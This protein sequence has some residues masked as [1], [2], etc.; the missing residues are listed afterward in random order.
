[1]LRRKLLVIL[2]PLVILLLGT[3]AGTVWL[4][5]EQESLTSRFRWLV[6]GIG[7]AF[8][9][10]INVAVMVLLRMSGMILRPIDRLVE[11]SRQLAQERFDHR[12]ELP[13]PDDEFHEL[14]RAYNVLA[15]Q[16]QANE[17]RKMEMLGQIALTLNHELNNA[18]AVIELRLRPLSRQCSGNPKMHDCFQQIHENLARMARTVDALKRVRRIVLTD[19]VSG[20]KMLDLER[21]VEAEPAAAA[22]PLTTPKTKTATPPYRAAATAAPAGAPQPTSRQD[23]A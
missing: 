18:L 22:V 2:G 15:A 21:S 17:Q 11:A 6:L 8:L 20:V 1:M 4:L 9:I 16:L 12:V 19:Y 14:A 23:P 10:V 13:G 5:E 7:V 3:M